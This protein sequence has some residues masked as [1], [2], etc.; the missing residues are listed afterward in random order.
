MTRL[1]LLIWVVL[2][3]GCQRED[4]DIIEPI[5]VI[6]AET[7]TF[8]DSH[9]IGK[10]TDVNG[11]AIEDVQINISDDRDYTT[12]KG[13]FL[14]NN[15]KTNSSGALIHLHKNDYYDQYVFVPKAANQFS[16][17]DV[18]LRKKSNPLIF[19]S[20]TP[21]ELPLNN[22]LNLTIPASAFT[23]SNGD[24]YQGQV[25]FYID[26]D[27][28][29]G[30][31]PVINKNFK[32][33]ILVSDTKVNF[34]FESVDG[35]PLV[36]S[37]PGTFS[38]KIK[39]ATIGSLDRNKA[40][41]VE[42]GKVENDKTFANIDHNGPYIIGQ[43]S[44]VTRIHTQVVNDVDAGVSFTTLSIKN[45]QQQTISIQPDQDGYAEFYVPSNTDISLAVT[46]VCGN[47]L[48][49]SSIRIGQDS[50]QQIPNIILKSQDL[51][52]VKSKI[53]ACGLPLS[54]QDLVNVHFQSETQN[55]VAYQSKNEQ[56][57]VIPSCTQIT[58]AS[59]YRGKERQF[60]ITFSGDI[61]THFLNIDAMPL[62]I[63]K[64]S[65]YF[66][67]NDV[68]VQLEMDQ[69]Y[70]YREHTDPKNVVITDL[71]GFVISI[72][73][74]DGKGQYKPDAIIFNHPSLSD[75]QLDSCRDMTVW[76]DE[77]SNPGDI[78]KIRIEGMMNGNKVEGE[79]VNLL[80]Y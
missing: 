64:I 2:L 12:E 29:S 46:D 75:C 13:I 4:S 55:L 37:K 27:P 60:S 18:V 49:E 41:W 23:H 79:F 28:I 1:Y 52:T 66:S 9:F 32:Q 24:A 77:I 21:N 35:S 65:G 36:I 51:L 72:P 30:N 53:D 43:F 59:Y 56:T 47:V 50:K 58:K 14:F 70:I 7:E 48:S 22:E 33:G 25:Q 57:Y 71:N 8:F 3:V 78:V 80:K 54:D 16:N 5:D 44:P 76:I 45:A 61:S 11:N 6:V 26:Y 68:P 15:T 38:T 10:T 63:E 42:I 19:N 34:I 73:N 74:V 17:L 62:C 20:A 31:I 67:V 39:N 40:K 69:F